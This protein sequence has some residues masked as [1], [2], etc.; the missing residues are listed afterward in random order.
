MNVDSSEEVAMLS[1]SY[2]PLSLPV[3]QERRVS[4]AERTTSSG[5]S[6]ALSRL[7]RRRGGWAAL[8]IV[9]LVTWAIWNA[10]C[11]LLESWQIQ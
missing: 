4:N 7:A 10:A 6:R 1:E 3:T 5:L 11:W 9:L 8:G 2:P